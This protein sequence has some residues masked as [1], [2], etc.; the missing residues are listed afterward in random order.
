MRQCFLQ[1]KCHVKRSGS[2]LSSEAKKKE[3][4]ASDSQRPSKVWCRAQWENLPMRATV[5]VIKWW[6]VSRSEPPSPR[7]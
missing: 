5:V 3:A 6:G 4:S 1:K 7:V 2:S